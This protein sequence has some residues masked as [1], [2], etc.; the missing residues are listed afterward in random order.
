[1]DQV[2]QRVMI[3][4]G[5]ILAAAAGVYILRRTVPHATLKE[6][7]EFGGLMY[8]LLGL[9]YGVYLAFTIIAVWEQFGNA[10]K[11]ATNE[12]AHLSELWRDA[13]MLPAS[14]RDLIQANLL[15]YTKDV[16]D[17][18]WPSMAAGK[19]ADTATANAYE[20]VWAAYYAVTPTPGDVQQSTFY[21]ES[22]RQLN[23]MGMLRRLRILAA[24]SELP[25]LMWT[26]LIV[27]AFVTIA[28][29][30]TFGTKHAITQYIVTMA[31]TGMLVFSIMMVAALE[32]P[33]SGDV[34]IKSDSFEG[35][36]KSLEK[37]LERQ[38]AGLPVG[39]AVAKH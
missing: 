27:G 35:V 29:M 17:K 11:A 12:A 21:G 25:Q 14:S 16:V 26:L 36:E 23:E 28:F 37:R 1:M 6:N 31:V 30:F 4:G 34:S 8:Q 5:S 20:G 38:H 32:H 9:V 3:V 15:T 33:F 2:T 18:E 7:H 22:I 10:E 39:G 19:G 24:D 13:Q